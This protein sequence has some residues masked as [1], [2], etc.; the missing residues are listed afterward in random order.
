M[1]SPL[2]SNSP[3]HIHF[4]LGGARSGKS[5][6]AE[7][8]ARQSSG[9]VV[10]V[11]TCS[12]SQP[13]D[14]EMTARVT[15]HRVRRPAE[16]KT[17]ENRFELDAVF[18]ECPGTTILVDC[19]TL[20][21]SWWAFQEDGC[22]EEQI[23]EKLE[24]ALAAVRANGIRLILV[25]NELGMGL[26]PLGEGNRDYRDLCGRA[27]QLVARWADEVEFVIAGLPLRLK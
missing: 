3:G 27:N 7:A 16:W 5:A 22:A 25:S 6:R 18:A 13:L 17:V 15:A 8:L 23:M 9:E 1:Q 24:R 14:P 11:A 19:L 21:L 4:L 26:V 2:S 12:T 10:Y 20:W